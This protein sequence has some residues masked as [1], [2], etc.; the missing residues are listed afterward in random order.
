MSFKEKNWQLYKLKDIIQFNPKESIKKKEIAKKIAMDKLEPFTRKV[1]GYEETEFTSGTKFRNGDTLLARITPC[2]ENGKTAQV[3]ILDENEIGFGS[4][5]YIVL[6][7]KLGITFNDYI[8]YLS[9]SPE[10]RNMA[11]KSMTGSSGRQ[12]VQKDVLEESEIIL[13]IL[14]EQKAIAKILS[15]LDEKIEVNNKINK[16]LEEMA[17]AIFKQ[18]FVDFEFPNEEGKPYKS[19]GGEMVESE[20]GMIPKGFKV[21]SIGE[22]PLIITDY[23]ANGS[24]KSL[25]ENVNM[26]DE[27]N[28]AIIVRNTDLKSNFKSDCKY[29]DK[30]SYDFLAK[31]KLFGGELIISNVGDVGSIYLCPKFKKQMTLGSNLIMIDTESSENIGFNLIL[32]RFFKSYIGQYYI[33]SITGG[34]AQP[35]FNKTDFKKIQFINPSNSILKLYN[36]KNEVIESIIMN[37][38]LENERLEKL[39]DTLLPKLMSGEIRVPLENNEI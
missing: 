20:L 30:K 1:S 17:Q 26:Y 14:E 8:Y 36:E 9:I 4:T 13:P 38:V 21:K 33:K 12:R 15:D 24:F 25:K 10:F 18:W 16:N 22:L 7:E 19:S 34:S 31:S 27:I 3:D 5:E 23:V 39:R 6:R 29:V 37:N 35:K 2:L 32:Y 11:I 28:Y